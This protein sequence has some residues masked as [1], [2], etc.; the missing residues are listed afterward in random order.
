[1]GARVNV[2]ARPWVV[3]AGGE[4]GVGQG[5]GLVPWADCLRCHRLSGGG[6]R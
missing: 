4:G 5:G 2:L 3:E 1:M 6:G